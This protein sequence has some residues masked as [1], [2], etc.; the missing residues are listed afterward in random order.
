MIKI[1][2]RPLPYYLQCFAKLN[3]NKQRGLVAPHKA[4]LLIAVMEDVAH[5]LITNGFVPVNDRMVDSFNRVWERLVGE[6]SV[7]NPVFSTPFYHLSSEPF[8]KLMRTDEYRQQREYSLPRL[9]ESFYGAKLPDD[10]M[11]YMEDDGCRR[12]LTKVLLERYIPNSDDDGF[13]IYRPIIAACERAANISADP[14]I[15]PIKKAK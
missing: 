15:S 5:G 1:T 13:I 7:F 10:L 12:L 4:V 11:G 3:C 6:S 9:R 8:W 2:N 14:P